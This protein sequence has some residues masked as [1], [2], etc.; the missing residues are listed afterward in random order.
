M[1]RLRIISI[2]VA[3]L[4]LG[5]LAI[6]LFLDR[7]PRYQG[8][9]LTQWVDDWIRIESRD[10]PSQDD[11]EAIGKCKHAIQ[12]IGTNAI[13]A[14]LKWMQA[15]DSP[16]RVKLNTVLDKQSLIKFRF[17]E[18][19]HCHWRGYMGFRALRKDAMAAVT[20]LTK[21][22]ESPD[23]GQ[24]RLVFESICAID[25]DVRNLLPVF[26]QSLQNSQANIR[27]SAAVRLIENYPAEAEKADV[28]KMFPEL[29]KISSNQSRTNQA[30]R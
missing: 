4:F 16:M 25:Y 12:Q 24:R 28:Y 6:T 27:L 19:E 1:K 18:A 29:R 22:L 5:I 11:E 10:F 8:R 23:H 30:P 21:L 2:V 7:E 20:D 17:P 3:V 26:L 9:T 13:P 15:A 14:L